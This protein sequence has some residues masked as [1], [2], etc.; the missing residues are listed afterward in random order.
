MASRLSAGGAAGPTAAHVS[1]FMDNGTSPIPLRRCEGKSQGR[2][3]PPMPSACLMEPQVDEGCPAELSRHR[4]SAQERCRHTSLDHPVLTEGTQVALD[5]I[6]WHASALGG[7]EEA[8]F[9]CI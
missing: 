7:Y 2:A 3:F 5:S 6:L 4:V 1:V 9:C 8:P